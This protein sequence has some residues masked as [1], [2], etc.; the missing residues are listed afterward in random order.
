LFVLLT[1]YNFSHRGTRP[2]TDQILLRAFHQL[3]YVNTRTR[4]NSAN[5]C[6]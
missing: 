2:L 1:K 3:Q 6:C 4:D 5:S